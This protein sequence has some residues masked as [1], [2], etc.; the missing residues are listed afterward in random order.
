VRWATASDYYRW[1]SGGRGLRTAGG[2]RPGL[3]AGLFAQGPTTVREPGPA[4]DHS[5]RMLRAMGTSLRIEGST[6][7][8]SPIRE[9]EPVCID[10]P[11]DF[12][13][14]AFLLTAGSLVPDGHLVVE[15][16]GLNDS[17]TGLL[18]VLREM[19]AKVEV[20]NERMV[21]QEPVGDLLVRSAELSATRVEG[22]LVVRMI[23]EFPALAVAAT[24]ARGE[25]V[26]R[27][28]AELR[29]KES[30]RIQAIVC[31]LRKL[32][33]SIEER[34]EGFVVRGPTPLCGTT[35]DSHGDHRLAMSL[36]VA[37]LIASGET[38]ISGSEC[39]EESYPG[40]EASLRG[41]C[42]AAR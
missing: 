1:R 34:A 25:T 16:V 18:D 27:D 7:V 41:L 11:G 20:E 30:D 5:E 39:I 2:V 26:V 10:T 29:V 6:I 40:F 36:A 23:D 3:L 8:L 19:G 32:G 13:S 24:Q 17:R 42:E 15:G 12:S 37:G 35:V 9:L 14:A 4:R 31:E 33:A 38:V 28:A 22:P 21:G